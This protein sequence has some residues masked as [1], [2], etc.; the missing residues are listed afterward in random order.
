MNSAICLSVG[1]TMC[2]TGTEWFHTVPS[3][4]SQHF[5]SQW[6]LLKWSSLQ[7]KFRE[8]KDCTSLPNLIICVYYFPV[9]LGPHDPPQKRLLLVPSQ[10]THGR[11]SWSRS[12]LRCAHTESRFLESLTFAWHPIHPLTIDPLHFNPRPSTT[13]LIQL[14]NWINC[15]VETVQLAWSC[16]PVANF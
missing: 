9:G 16:P 12:S 6:P 14:L 10:Y 2:Y 5:F 11:G 3:T 15:F 8:K 13:T 4:K 1:H 7:L